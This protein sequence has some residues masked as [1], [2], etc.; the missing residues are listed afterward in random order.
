MLS[1]LEKS[2]EK[3]AKGQREQLGKRWPNKSLMKLKI[4]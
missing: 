1:E 3:L 2:A 4:R